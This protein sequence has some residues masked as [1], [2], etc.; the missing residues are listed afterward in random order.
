MAQDVALDVLMRMRRGKWHVTPQTLA[1][2]V[3][4]IA[5]Q[6]AVD[7]LRRSKSRAKRNA[8][9]GREI[10]EGTHAWMRPDLAAEQLHLEKLHETMLD[11]LPKASR[12][13]YIM[14]RQDGSTYDAVAEALGISVSAVS[15]SVVRA[16]RLLRE[17]LALHE[18]NAPRSRK[19]SK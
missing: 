17:G 4:R 9:H 16:Q 1:P 3:K 18:I 11:E 8:E 2:H 12:L 14:V 5:R 13:V 15:R 19:R 7:L 10:S 6:R